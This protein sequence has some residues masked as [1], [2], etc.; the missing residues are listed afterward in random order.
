[1]SCH[2]RTTT[3]APPTTTTTTS[4]APAPTVLYVPVG[5]DMQPILSDAAET[6]LRGYG[7][8]HM[9]NLAGAPQVAAELE[10]SGYITALDDI[11]VF[12]ILT[13]RGIA[14]AEG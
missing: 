11:G 13:P 8:G 5:P 7:W 9:L 3:A 14:R 1:M 2:T 12:F 10:A 4:P 6:A